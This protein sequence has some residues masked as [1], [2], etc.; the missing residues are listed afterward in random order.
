[1]TSLDEAESRRR[2]A[3]ARVAR[4][5]TATPDGRPHLVPIVFALD[6]DTIYHGVDAKPKRHTALRRLANLAANPR[7]AVLVDHYDDDWSQLWWVRADGGARDVLPDAPEG[8]MAVDRLRQ[9]YPAFSLR[10][11]LVAIDVTK[12]TGWSAARKSDI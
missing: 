2:F 4:M 5:A 11:G 9:R 10:G 12:W 7:A 1:M 6:A 8:L 3:A